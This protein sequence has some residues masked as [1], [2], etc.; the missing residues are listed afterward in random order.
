MPR[1][2]GDLLLERLVQVLGAADEAHRRQAVAALVE[3]ARARRRSPRD[4]S[5]ARGSCWRRTPAPR[6]RRRAATSGPCGEAQHALVLPQ[7]GR[8]GSV[9]ARPRARPQRRRTR[10]TSVHWREALRAPRHQHHL[11]GVAR[12]RSSAI[13]S[14]NSSIGMTCVIAGRMS[15]R[16]EP[17]QVVHLVPGLVHAPA[18]DAV[19]RD[20][21]E[22]HQ[23]V[24]VQLERLLGQAR[25]ATCA[26]R[27][28]APRGRRAPPAG[29]P[30]SRAR[31]RARA[32][33]SAPARARRSLAATRRS[34]RRPSSC[35]RARAGRARRR[36][37][38]RVRR[39][40]RARTPIAN[41]PIGP[42]PVTAMLQPESGPANAVCTALP[43]G[44]ITAATSIGMLAGARHALTAGTAT[45]SAKPPFT[46]TP[47]MRVFSHTWPL[48]VRQAMQC[49]QT[50]WLSHETRSP[51][52][53]LGDAGAA[54]D[55]LA[56]ELVA[57]RDRRLEP[58]LRPAVPARRCGG[59]C[60]TRR[61]AAR[62]SSSSPGPQVGTGTSRISAPGPRRRLD[63]SACMVR[64]AWR[65]GRRSARGVVGHAS[66]A[67]GLRQRRS[68]RARGT[69]HSRSASGVRRRGARHRLRASRRPRRRPPLVAALR[70]EV[71]DPVGAS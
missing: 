64:G 8:R 56:H 32:R 71:D 29:C 55:H 68:D 63:A 54:L 53:E 17:Q 36:W 60:R 42:Q 62:C 30:T 61:R 48:P 2:L 25:A 44:S 1:K 13:A 49:W 16:P 46:S 10:V 52:R 33:R 27:C 9:A 57:E 34:P 35:A 65:V 4:G 47:R 24:P 6:A 23:P 45:Y 11:A 3:R 26:R 66:S 51:S 7:A 31:R 50:M 70:P 5:R 15:S 12:A 20:A 69:Q 18:D 19:D 38:T 43:S 59:R 41:R 28:A 21:L 22:D 39:P 14:S 58:P 37:R 40:P 67:S